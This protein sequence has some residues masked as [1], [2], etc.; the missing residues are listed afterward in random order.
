MAR[1]KKTVAAPVEEVASKE[2]V[3][4]IVNEQSVEKGDKD[5][6][7]FPTGKKPQRKHS[8]VCNP[9]SKRFN[10]KIAKRRAKE[11]ARRKAARKNR[12]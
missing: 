2:E 6:F 1:T 9:K 8:P 4:G 11:K 10:A 3:I 5:V 12:K 7:S